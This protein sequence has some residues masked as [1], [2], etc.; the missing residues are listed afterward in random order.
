MD[1]RRFLRNLLSG[2]TALAIA[3]ALLRGEHAFAGDP[4]RFAEGLREH[5]W[6]A[7]WKSVSSESI[8][9][10]TLDIEGNLPKGFAGTLYRNGPA[11]FERE[12][13]NW[14]RFYDAVRQLTQQP[15]PQ[16]HEALRALL[17]SQ[18]TPS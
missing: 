13:R 18:T 12:G 7:G 2:A 15:Q 4:A 1:R 14:P 11:L 16:R 8:A 3:P 9:P 17:P 10:L 6:L 5:P